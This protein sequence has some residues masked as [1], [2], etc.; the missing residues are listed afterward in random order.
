MRG[1]LDM[2]DIPVT[3]LMTV[4]NGGAFLAPAV[5]SVLGQ[6]FSEFEFLIIDD[7]SH[8]DSVTTIQSFSDHRIV[9][10]R[11]QENRGQTASLN[12][13]LR[14]ARGRYI[15]RIDADDL[16]FPG[17]LERQWAFI[18]RHPDYAVVSANAVMID[19]QGR[20]L[21]ELRSLTDPRD[22]RLKSMLASPINHG[23]ALM[24]KALVLE[25]GGYDEAQRV[26]ADYGLWS[27][28]LRKGYPITS[29]DATLMAIRVH[30]GQSSFV[31][32]QEAYVP[33]LTGIMQDNIHDLSACD[34]RRQ[35]IERALPGLLLHVDIVRL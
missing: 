31:S 21:R 9:L 11:N 15:A 35:D 22:M 14:L 29:T 8:D 13:G 23:V 20:I 3:V 32:G 26:V 30:S 34:C 7:C 17:W 12:L 16:A 2:P 25:N 33:E 27:R 19:E 5:R 24:N 18:E 10:H 6:T 28:L 1:T 4:Y